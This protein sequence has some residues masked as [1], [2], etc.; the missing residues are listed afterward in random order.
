MFKCIF[1]MYLPFSVRNKANQVNI[2]RNVQGATDSDDY[3]NGALKLVYTVQYR[4]KLVYINP[5]K[6]ID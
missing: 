2:V 5:K 6:N 1:I 4:I 3:D